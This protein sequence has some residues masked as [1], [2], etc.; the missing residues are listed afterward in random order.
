MTKLRIINI[1]SMSA[2]VP[3]F[4]AFIFPVMKHEHRE[5]FYSE[6]LFWIWG[7]PFDSPFSVIVFVFTLP[8]MLLSIGIIFEIVLLLKSFIVLLKDNEKISAVS[9]DWID[10]GRHIIY[11]ELLWNLWLLII[12]F[13]YPFGIYYIEPPIFL[14]LV[15]GV[16]LIIAGN[17][18]RRFDV[19]EESVLNRG[20]NLKFMSGLYV[21]VLVLYWLFFLIFFAFFI[22][23]PLTYLE[24]VHYYR[25]LFGIY[26]F[27]PTLL[28]LLIVKFDRFLDDVKISNLHEHKRLNTLY[29]TT[30]VVIGILMLIYF[31]LNLMILPIYADLFWWD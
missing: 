13:I 8:F 3:L 30:L 5:Y 10:R 27:T 11:L 1:L 22:F 6:T 9:S 21:F 7:L 15:G 2:L 23:P 25:L 26:Y 12:Q 4:S 17:L 28:I 14:P 19:D 29:I 24:Y 16:I 18:Y 31:L 20:S